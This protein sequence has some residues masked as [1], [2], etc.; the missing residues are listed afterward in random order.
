MINNFNDFLFESNSNTK[1]VNFLSTL[2]RYY[3]FNTDNFDIEK[4]HKQWRETRK[5]AEVGKTVTHDATYDLQCKME[6][7]KYIVHCE[8]NF[9]FFGQHSKDYTDFSE[10]RIAVILDNLEIKHLKIE[11]TILNYD[12]RDIS[13]TI[14]SH[15]ESFLIKMMISDYDQTSSKIYKKKDSLQQNK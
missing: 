3:N 6:N 8:Y 13:D 12:S 9:S 15:M 2:T 10:D 11:S 5:Y 4:E 1:V 14:K 7:V